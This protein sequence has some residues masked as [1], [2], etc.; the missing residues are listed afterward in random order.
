MLAAGQESE[1]GG[2][3]LTVDSDSNELVDGET[4]SR[5][6]SRDLLDGEEL[7]ELGIRLLDVDVK[8]KLLSDSKRGDLAESLKKK[9]LALRFQ[10]KKTNYKKLCIGNRQTFSNNDLRS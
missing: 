5:D 4:I 2:K 10:K 9:K 8:T 1:L 3:K 6:K 7:S